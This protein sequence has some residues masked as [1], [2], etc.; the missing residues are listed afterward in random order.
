[1]NFRNKTGAPKIIKI[2]GK[3]FTII[4][5]LGKNLSLFGVGLLRKPWNS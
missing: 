2:C 3:L 4:L 5:A 1:M